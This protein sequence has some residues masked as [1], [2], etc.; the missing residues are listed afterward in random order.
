MISRAA[1]LSQMP[2]HEVLS[3]TRQTMLEPAAR[4]LLAV[5]PR[6]NAQQALVLSYG[7]RRR[8]EGLAVMGWSIREIARRANVQDMTVKRPRSAPR[9]QWRVHTLIA[10]VYEELS[11][12][13]RDNT[14]TVLWAEANGFV[15]PMLWDDIDDYYEVPVEPVDSKIPDEIV[16]QRLADG[17]AVDRASKAERAA[18]VQ[19]L[20]DRGLSS[21]AIAE[22]MRVSQRQ[23]VRD[24]GMA[25]AS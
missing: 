2:A 7:A 5:T 25:V 24:R 10:D 14:R 22:R 9:V 23:V 20:T 15:H 11:H 8:L 13:R 4:A 18:A 16:I 3:D 12:I 21:A 6:P 17:R 19:I 1:G